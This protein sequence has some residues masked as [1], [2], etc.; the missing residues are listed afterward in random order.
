MTRQRD[1]DL[2]VNEYTAYHTTRRRRLSSITSH[3]LPQYGSAG[4]AFA[5]GA[6]RRGPPGG[7]PSGTKSFPPKKKPHS[8]AGLR[9]KGN[10][11]TTH[12]T[13]TRY[14]YTVHLQSHLCQLNAALLRPT[15]GRL[16]IAPDAQASSSAAVATSREGQRPP[17]AG[18]EVQHRRWDLGQ[19]MRLGRKC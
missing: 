18:Q 13:L 19:V 7:V 15:K 4:P 9:T 17:T 12:G 5:G 11:N 8:T 14:T 1:C 10:P 2:R 16:R 3:A 6:E